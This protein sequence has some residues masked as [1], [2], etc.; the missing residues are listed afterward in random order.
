MV[1]GDFSKEDKRNYCSQNCDV[2]IRNGMINA[3]VT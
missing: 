1:R 2:N 3:N